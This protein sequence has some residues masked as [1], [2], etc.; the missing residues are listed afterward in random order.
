MRQP[1][2]LEIKEPA[3]TNTTV[4]LRPGPGN[5]VFA[6]FRV[7]SFDRDDLVINGVQ[8]AVIVSGVLFEQATIQPWESAA[9]PSFFGVQ[10]NLKNCGYLSFVL[11]NINY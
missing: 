10:R 7:R 11:F 8:W 4:P 1:D 2:C 6:S 5:V 3:D 9:N